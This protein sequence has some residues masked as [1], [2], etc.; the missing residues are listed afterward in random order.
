[1]KS[2]R[3]VD[4]RFL[5][6]I[7]SLFELNLGTDSMI[8]FETIGNATV[9]CHDGEPILSTDPWVDGSPYFGS[10][11]LPNEVPSAQREAIVNSKFIWFSHGHPD[12]FLAESLELVAHRKILLPDHVG[13]RIYDNLKEAGIGRHDSSGSEVDTALNEYQNSLYYRLLSGCRTAH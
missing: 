13:S 8:G 2:P 7:Y 10:W 9:I 3:G 12:H 5:V 4:R 6:C 1:M 11:G